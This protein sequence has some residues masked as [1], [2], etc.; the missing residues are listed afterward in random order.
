MC[1]AL[2]LLKL[3]IHGARAVLVRDIDNGIDE[4]VDELQHLRRSAPAN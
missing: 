3:T 1:R 4:T 2:K